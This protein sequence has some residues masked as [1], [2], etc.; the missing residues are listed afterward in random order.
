LH[1]NCGPPPVLLS[2]GV[3][4]ESS[5]FFSGVMSWVDFLQWRTCSWVAFGRNQGFRKKTMKAQKPRHVRYPRALPRRTAWERTHVRRH[6]EQRERLHPPS[7]HV[8][9][10]CKVWK[11][12]GRK[13]NR[14][15]IRDHKEGDS[16]NQHTDSMSELNTPPDYLYAFTLWKV[17]S[18][19]EERRHLRTSHRRCLSAGEMS[20]TSLEWPEITRAHSISFTLV[21]KN[22]T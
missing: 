1:G 9:S 7:S 20:L 2:R 11:I 16:R 12:A 18:N 4:R 17:V 3:I 6:R 21:L 8:F 5:S 13:C 19:V 10:R 14:K 15:W 22:N